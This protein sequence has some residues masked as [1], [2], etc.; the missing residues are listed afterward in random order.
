M[1]KSLENYEPDKN[2]F[3]YEDQ[4]QLIKNSEIEGTV[5]LIDMTNSTQLKSDDAFPGWVTYIEKFHKL[6]FE[7]FENKGLKEK[8]KWYKFLGDAYMFFFSKSENCKKTMIKDLEKPDILSIFEEI[9]NQFWEF[10][11]SYSKRD[12]GKPK[13]RHFRE[14]TCAITCG[15]EITNWAQIIDDNNE[16]FDP[17]GAPIDLCFRIS[18]IAGPGQLLVSKKF[19]SELP[20]KNQ[21][22]FEKITIKKNTLK[23]FP[24]ENE[25]Y[26]CLPNDEQRNYIVSKE[27]VDLIE[28]TDTMT[29]KV[30]VRLLRKK[31]EHLENFKR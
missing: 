1:N 19:F 4:K 22:K 6:I 15:S 5:V 24:K 14:I 30:K 28:E 2:Q 3:D 20:K 16:N 26:Y 13:D 8:V 9:M 29:T 21:E 31:I 11:K 25:I 12:R 27:N 23:G 18:N 17:I 10:Y 7:C